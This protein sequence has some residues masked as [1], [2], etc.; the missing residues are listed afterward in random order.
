LAGLYLSTGNDE[1]LE[2]IGD[3]SRAIN[4]VARL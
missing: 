2:I 3:I 4:R 1:I